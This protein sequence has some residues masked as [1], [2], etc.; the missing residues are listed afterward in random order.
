MPE[1]SEKEA[2]ELLPEKKFEEYPLAKKITAWVV[3]IGRVVIIITELIA[4]SVFVGRIKLDR[5]LTD[6]TDALENQLI[7]LQNAQGFEGEFKDLQKRLEI[8]KELR[9]EQVT[10]SQ[11][12]SL[13]SALLPQNVELTG[14]TIEPKAGESYLLAK[15]NSATGFARAINNLKSSPQIEDIALTSGRFSAKDGTYH[16][17]LAL[18][19]MET[20]KH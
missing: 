10:T 6:L 19:F 5:Q 7:I 2:I 3:S 15:T 16:F 13:L 20:R 1:Q 4:F 8:I 14:L 12:T 11:T 9:R 18:K 17:S